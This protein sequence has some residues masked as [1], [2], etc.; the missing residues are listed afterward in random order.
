MTSWGKKLWREVPAIAVPTGPGS[1]AR[2]PLFILPAHLARRHGMAWCPPSGVLQRLGRP[3]ASQGVQLPGLPQVFRELG[4]KP[5]QSRGGLGL[6]LACSPPTSH[7]C[8]LIP[9]VSGRFPH[10]PLSPDHPIRGPAELPRRWLALY[11]FNPRAR[12]WR[13]RPRGPAGRPTRSPVSGPPP[14]RAPSPARTGGS[15]GARGRPDLERCGHS[16]PFPGGWA[17]T[18]SLTSRAAFVLLKPQPRGSRTAGPMGP[19]PDCPEFFLPSLI[20]C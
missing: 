10:K 5:P 13:K 14:S 2:T 8:P 18:A 19:N 1:S 17:C 16:D 9:N 11:K 4:P 12:T 20:V 6:T 3:P 15:G 7:G